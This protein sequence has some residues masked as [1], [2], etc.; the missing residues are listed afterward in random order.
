MIRLQT[1]EGSIRS[2]IVL[3]CRHRRLLTFYPKF[4]L[5]FL[6]TR[7][8]ETSSLNF[9]LIFGDWFIRFPECLHKPFRTTNYTQNPWQS[10]GINW[11]WYPDG[12]QQS[13]FLY[14]AGRCKIIEMPWRWEHV[15]HD[16]LMQNGTWKRVSSGKPFDHDSS[17]WNWT[18]KSQEAHPYTYTLKNGT[19]QER[20]ATIGVEEREWRWKW[21]TWLPWPR[22]VRRSIDVRFDQEVGE[23][24]GSW[25]GGT[26]GCGYNMQPGE[27]PIDT[28]RRMEKERKFS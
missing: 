19:V 27:R 24:T 21:L 2:G 4:G 18:D 7:G 28:L 5:A 9:Q 25:K 26:V 3:Y 22:K 17:P 20:T 14:W 1:E 13:I 15:R 16:V 23:R 6:F 8:E 11:G 10:F 12:F